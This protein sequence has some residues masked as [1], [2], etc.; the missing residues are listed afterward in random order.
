MGGIAADGIR[1][2]TEAGLSGVTVALLD[3]AGNIIATTTTGASGIFQFLGV[4]AGKNYR[5]RVTDAAAV[6]NNYYPTTAYAVAGEF[7]MPGNLAGDLNYTA[8]PHFGYNL[9][10][11]I[12]D[13]VFNDIDGS[14]VQNGTEP[15]ISG[16][17]RAPLSRRTATAPSSLAGSTACRWG[18]W[19]RTAMAST[20]SPDLPTAATG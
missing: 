14:A 4:A 18:G 9:T 8:A 13:T 3:N 10:R 17:T 2:G 20:S 5:W 7:Q 1:N 6:L 16:V 12:G 11:A 19:S 15:G